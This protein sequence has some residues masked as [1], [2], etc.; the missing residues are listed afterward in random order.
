MYPHRRC[1]TKN[2]KIQLCNSLVLSHL[3]YAS[4]VYARSIE[5]S[6]HNRIQR[7]Q[8]SCQRF[9]FGI[10]SVSLTNIK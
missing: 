5:V 3:S 10:V 4:P 9:I 1:M 8:N 2:I 7:L 6:D